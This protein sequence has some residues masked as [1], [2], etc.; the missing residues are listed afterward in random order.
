MKLVQACLCARNTRFNYRGR[1]VKHVPACLRASKDRERRF[2]HCGGSG[3]LVK[4]TL[5]AVNTLPRRFNRREGAM[6]HVQVYLSASKDGE[7]SF[8]HSGGPVKLVQ[9]CLCA[10]TPYNVVI[11]AKEVL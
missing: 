10:G 6:K 9:A 3:K 11:T 4:A 7:S 5:C 2:H 8:H 1:A